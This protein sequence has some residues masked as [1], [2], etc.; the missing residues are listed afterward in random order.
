MSDI[1]VN[2]IKSS[3]ATIKKFVEDHEKIGIKNPSDLQILFSKA[4]PEIYDNYA[5]VV[6]TICRKDDLTFL[7]KMIESLEKVDKGKK[8]IKEVSNKLGEELADKYLYPKVG[9]NNK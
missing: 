7:N 6:K 9:K 8:T 2:L 5:T 4:H 1:D 3:V